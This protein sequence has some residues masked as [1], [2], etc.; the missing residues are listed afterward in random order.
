MVPGR[1]AESLEVLQEALK[2]TERL[3]GLEGDEALAQALRARV[4]IRLDSGWGSAP[5][6][7]WLLARG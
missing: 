2:E 5:I 4:E 1:T 7:E 6:I 3:L